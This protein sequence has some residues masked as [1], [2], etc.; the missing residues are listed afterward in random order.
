MRKLQWFLG[1]FLLSLQIWGQIQERT[2]QASTIENIMEVDSLG[3]N[4]WKFSFRNSPGGHNSSTSYFQVIY[5][6]NQDSLGPLKKVSILNS[7]TRFSLPDLP[8]NSYQSFFFHFDN[9]YPFIGASWVDL[10]SPNSS[11][12]WEAIDTMAASLNWQFQQD[13]VFALFGSKSI[14]QWNANRIGSDTL[15]LVHIKRPN[16]QMQVLD[17]FL[18]N[19]PFLSPGIFIMQDDAK[20]FEYI[21][22]D[23]HYHFQR[24]KQIAD[25]FYID[26]GPYF[27][28]PKQDSTRNASFD[29]NHKTYLNYANGK[30]RIVRDSLGA[31]LL[32]V[33]ELLNGKEIICKTIYLPPNKQYAD[34]NFLYNIQQGDVCSYAFFDEAKINFELYRMDG[35]QLKS[36]Q[37]YK[38]PS[39][40]DFQIWQIESFSDGSFLLMGEI[41]RGL[42]PGYDDWS[43]AHF[44][45]LDP[46]RNQLLV[47]STEAFNV[48]LSPNSTQLSVFYPLGKAQLQFRILDASGRSLQEGSFIAQ[49][50]ISIGDWRP[51]IY[52]LQLWNNDGAYLGQQSFLK[53]N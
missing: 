30:R 20:G 31:D 35:S 13:S 37:S 34:G 8:I 11:F 3:P 28:G 23:I 48:H 24:G 5:Y 53:G 40:S 22:E 19:E 49:E 36:Q 52:Y 51:G 14:S 46:S 25:S 16:K 50:G 2:F 18:L 26:R 7:E 17:T 6:R 4:E 9:S 10:K 38:L 47:N 21:N 39:N 45:Y 33:E 12:S 29:L 32:V 15:L 42:S 43:K 1:F 27:E 41:D 44:V